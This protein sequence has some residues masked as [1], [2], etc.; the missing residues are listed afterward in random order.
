[1]R[2]GVAALALAV[3]LGACAADDPGPAATAALPSPTVGAGSGGTPSP[4]GAQLSSCRQ[5]QGEPQSGL[6]TVEVAFGS[7]VVTAEV[8]S[9]P[10]QRR[11]GLMHRTELGED[12]GML[13]LFPD[14]LSGGF[15]MCNTRIPLAIAYL[16]DTG[17]G[18]FEVVAIRRMQPCPEDRC[19]VYEPG[20][21][22]DA[23]LEVNPD[24][25]DEAGVAVGSRAEPSGELPNPS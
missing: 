6:P 11:T 17:E 2:A 14:P 23:A 20:A 12:A 22:Y 24:W 10:A 15:W 21:A 16:R 8:V 18:T 25:F 4:V 9:T 1:M 7:R 13:F 19:P 5:E 3:V